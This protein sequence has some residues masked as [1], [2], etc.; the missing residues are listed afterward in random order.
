MSSTDEG[1]RDPLIENVVRE[2]QKPVALDP[3]LDSRI[4]A[5]VREPPLL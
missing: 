3:E 2:L 5:A 4:M 1:P